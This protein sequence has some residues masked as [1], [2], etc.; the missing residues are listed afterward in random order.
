[1][2]H[3]CGSEE[4]SGRIVD[5]QTE[6][7]ADSWIKTSDPIDLKMPTPLTISA[8]GSGQWT[9][10]PPWLRATTKVLKLTPCCCYR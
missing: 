3:P 9:T 5:G 2:L 4:I 10:K 7:T 8:Q 1:V 6:E